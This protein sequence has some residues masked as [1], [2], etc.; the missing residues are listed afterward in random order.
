MTAT[1]P[2]AVLSPEFI[3]WMTKEVNRGTV[4][5]LEIRHNEGCPS[6][7][8]GGLYACTCAGVEWR[9]VDEESR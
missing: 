1:A 8:G 7:N 6:L 5:V 2:D 4:Q 3:Y 9:M